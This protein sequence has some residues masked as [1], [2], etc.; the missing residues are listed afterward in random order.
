MPSCSREN[1]GREPQRGPQVPQD[2][3]P[4]RHLAHMLPLA[5]PPKPEPSTSHSVYSSSNRAR[6]FPLAHGR[7]PPA[8]G[9]SLYSRV[10][11]ASV[12]QLRH[13]EAC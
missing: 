11:G 13:R 3:A 10:L 7:P 6:P 4:A 5:A 8:V 12:Y 1:R 9:Q 2:P